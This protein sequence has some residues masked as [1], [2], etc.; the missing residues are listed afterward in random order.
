MA[1]GPKLS[2]R[3]VHREYLQLLRVIRRGDRLPVGHVAMLTLPSAG[4][5]GVML[6]G[7]LIIMQ[8]RA[9]R[10]QV[11]HELVVRNSSVLLIYI[12]CVQLGTHRM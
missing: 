12:L 5:R 4:R 7:G 3:A 11:Q 2:R 10:R 8:L 6:I 1:R 9:S